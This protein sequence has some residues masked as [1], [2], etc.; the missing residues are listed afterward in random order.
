M[1]TVHAMK[2]IITTIA[3]NLEETK[4][5]NRNALKSKTLIPANAMTK[6]TG[7]RADVKNIILVI[8]TNIER[9]MV[10]NAAAADNRRTHPYWMGSFF[11][12]F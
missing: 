11:M 5:L 8:V 2:I 12:C 7:I 9:I 10:K 6:K 1:D 3:E 4:P